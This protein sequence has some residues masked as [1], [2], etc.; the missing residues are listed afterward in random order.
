MILWELL[1]EFAVLIVIFISVAIFIV[2]IIIDLVRHRIFVL[3]RVDVICKKIE[4][5]IKNIGA[6]CLTLF[7]VPL[8]D[9]NVEKEDG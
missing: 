4:N 1:P 7:H 9:E 8:I 5:L 6:R 2:C 3:I